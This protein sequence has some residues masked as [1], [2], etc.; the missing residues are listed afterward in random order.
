[1]HGAVG[2]ETFV[3][4]DADGVTHLTDDADAIPE[5]ARDSAADEA[6]ERFAALWRD[7]VVGPLLETPLADG[8]SEDA[9]IA[10]LLAGA[11]ADIVRGEHARATAALRSLVRLDP[12]RPEPYWYLAELERQRGRYA[13]AE[14]QLAEFVGRAKSPRYARW[15]DAAIERMGALGDERRLADPDAERPPL[16]LVA[17]ES[18]HFR[19][20]LD[21][22][23]DA[24]PAYGERV[25]AHLE[26]ARSDVA[27]AIGVLPSEPLGV[28]FYGNAAYQRAHKHR[29][30][31]KTVGFFDG[32]IHV[33]ATADPGESLRAL[34]YHEYTH[35]LF[36]ERTGGDRPYWLNEGLAELVERRARRLP[37]S[38]RSER[39]ALRTRIEGDA[40]IPLRRIAPSFGGLTGDD[41]RAAYLQA[42]VT[43]EW[44]EANTD[45]AARGRLLERLGEGWSI[46]QALYEAVGTDTDGVDRLVR[47]R[48]TEEFPELA[49]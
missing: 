48:I 31:F 9:R 27:D 47:L 28:V 36:R 23:L 5:A 18:H 3:W 34:L 35:A 43:A 46:D 24:R 10:R 13:S 16:A 22:E 38:T 29:F 19:V 44:L 33:A 37:T 20:E 12:T 1:M 14:Q 32:R 40:W 2:A 45:A 8:G 26:A 15:R 11:R 25:L 49:D 41:A 30:S 21:S 7:G 39:A 17:R 42:I 6:P 4:V